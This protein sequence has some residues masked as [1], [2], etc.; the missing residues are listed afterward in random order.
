MNSNH[1]LSDIEKILQ[2]QTWKKS[3]LPVLSNKKRCLKLRSITEN[4]KPRKQDRLSTHPCESKESDTEKDEKV[5]CPFT[6]PESKKSLSSLA[7]PFEI[8]SKA[9]NSV[10]VKTKSFDFQVP[11]LPKRKFGMSSKDLH[12]TPKFECVRLGFP[13]EE[14]TRMKRE[15]GRI[16]Q[17]SQRTTRKKF[18]FSQDLFMLSRDNGGKMFLGLFN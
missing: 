13:E 1:N 9:L 11:L 10:S 3:H 8:M 5:E 17:N 12:S 18:L 14:I 7:I 2:T 6:R 16:S 15:S 4:E